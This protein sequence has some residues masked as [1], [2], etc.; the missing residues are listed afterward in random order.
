MIYSIAKNYPGKLSKYFYQLFIFNR[1]IPLIYCRALV[2]TLKYTQTSITLHNRTYQK[3]LGPIIN[4][5]LGVLLESRIQVSIL[6][7][8]QLFILCDLT[9]NIYDIN[10]TW[11][12]LP[13]RY[14]DDFLSSFSYP[15]PKF[16]LF[17]IIYVAC[18]LFTHHLFDHLIFDC[19]QCII[20]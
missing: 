1:K 6:N 2:Q 10:N 18:C 11:N 15:W 17:L 16:F 8:H 12:T 5:V 3:W 20:Q 19:I 9:Y 7:I 4:F 13:C 14:S